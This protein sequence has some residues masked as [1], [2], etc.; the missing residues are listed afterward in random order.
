VDLRKSRP[1]DHLPA[2]IEQRDLRLHVCQGDVD[3]HIGFARR[4]GTIEMISKE[5]LFHSL[6]AGG[7]AFFTLPFPDPGAP[8]IRHLP[9]TGIVEFT[10]AAGYYWMR[11]YLLVDDHPY[12]A[13]T[14]AVGQF[15]LEQV[16]PGEYE[17]VCWLPNWHQDGQERELETGLVYRI[18]FRR[19][20]ERSRHVTVEKGENRQVGFSFSSRDFD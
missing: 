14:N 6:H 2:L 13:R 16:P 5:N 19:A 18:S 1:W 3:S 15:L 8:R 17:V 9:E 11:A 10:S 12:Y 20:V 4:R 7:A